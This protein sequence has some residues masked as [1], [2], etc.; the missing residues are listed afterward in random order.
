MRDSSK[1]VC[2]ICFSQVEAQI[3]GLLAQSH[4]KR[5]ILIVD[6]I[7]DIAALMSV[8]VENAGYEAHVAEDGVEALRLARELRPDLIVM[9][10]MMPRMDGVE[11]LTRM[12]R[13]PVLRN[14]KVVIHSALCHR[15]DF[16]SQVL[17]L[18]ALGCLATPF[19]SKE[20]IAV[21]HRVL[22]D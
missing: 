14:L 21:V 19:S 15:P 13:D 11:A 12:K 9:N 3:D 22:S 16:R 10:V 8:M 4:P 6:D 7:L 20:L 18:G 2:G 17:E 5:C 1:H